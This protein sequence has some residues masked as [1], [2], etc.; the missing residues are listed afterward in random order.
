[1]KR[2]AVALVSILSLAAIVMAGPYDGQYDAYKVITVTPTVT[3]GDLA[4]QSNF[5]LLVRFK[6]KNAS[7]GSDV[8]LGS[9]NGGLD[10]RFTTGDGSTPL[11]FERERWVVDSAAD[12][13]VRIPTMNGTSGGLGVT[14]QI[15]VYYGKTGGSDSSSSSAVFD[16]AA[17]FRAV[18]HMNGA[19]ANADENDATQNGFTATSFGTSGAAASFGGIAGG[20]DFSTHTSGD[21]S[22]F[23]IGR[24]QTN[25]GLHM[26]SA[27]NG[28]A[29]G[30][31]ALALYTTDSGAT[32][33]TRKTSSLRQYLSLNGVACSPQTTNNCYAVG[34]TSYPS[35]TGTVRFVSKS[36]DGGNTW[37]KQDSTTGSQTLFGV[38]CNSDTSC[39]AVGGNG[40]TRYYSV[41]SAN[42]STWAA[43]STASNHTMQAV[44]C[45][46]GDSTCY[47]VGGGT[48]TTRTVQRFVKSPTT[49]AYTIVQQENTTSS[50]R[51]NGV[52]C[53]SLDVC[54]AVG[55]V[56]T[57]IKTTTGSTTGTWSALT[58]GTTKDLSAI[59]CTDANTCVA[60]GKAI[61][62]AVYTNGDTSVVL[63]TTDGGTS[64]NPKSVGK[65]NDSLY[66]VKFPSTGFGIIV[67]A[68]G[69]VLRSFDGGETWTMN[70]NSRKLAMSVNG[71][72]DYVANAGGSG[73]GDNYAV[74]SWA[75]V[76]AGTTGRGQQTIIGKGDFHWTLQ[77]S[78]AN[79]WNSAERNW[80]ACGSNP[81]ASVCAYNGN[82]NWQNAERNQTVATG[83]HY[84]VSQRRNS[85]DSGRIYVDGGA[86]C[87]GTQK[88]T[89]NVT[90]GGVGLQ[91]ANRGFLDIVGIGRGTDAYRRFWNRGPLDE[92]RVDAVARSAS[93]ICLSY[94]T[95]NPDTAAYYSRVS[96]GGPVA[97]RASARE[98]MSVFQ[99]AGNGNYSFAIP[100]GMA[101]S[102]ELR[103][104][105]V[106]GR[107]VWS[108]SVRMNGKAQT[109]SWNGVAANGS[110]ATSGV[111]FARLK[112]VNQGKSQEFALKG[113]LTH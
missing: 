102:A 87:S 11:A 22:Y 112:T 26:T 48:T 63:K 77:T 2:L 85:V 74:S 86:L 52:H 84:L 3:G 79:L 99:I 15:R 104:V 105:D 34:G 72:Y 113:S 27:S 21:S 42:A 76:G 56:G 4:N 39:V 37:A 12:F 40:T 83:W 20:R 47:A 1:M 49:G 92:I 59:Y 9:K 60:V 100:A 88:D 71:S 16:T 44:Y 64:W 35:G 110:R 73:K 55:N 18:Y 10:I 32:W 111:Y 31:G 58:S 14:T 67:G 66:A 53:P 54:Y 65:I 101:E 7:T 30:I 89:S 107:T 23:L 68:N 98:G 46:A 97:L 81:N 96:M 75:N 94:Q 45:V 36:T 93:W 6:A 43:T 38:S 41:L 25:F 50:G 57:I 62:S 28:V 29:V 103:I 90:G 61:G 106:A 17:G 51:L 13:W 108:S 70:G 109:I 82:T 24:T 80:M 69:T 33:S 5:P 91:T 95:Q 78:S 19:S 8:L